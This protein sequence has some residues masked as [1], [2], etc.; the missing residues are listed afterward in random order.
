MFVTRYLDLFTTFYSVYNS[1]VK[2]LYITATAT[3]IWLIRFQQPINYNFEQDSFPHWKFAVAPC[4]L[5]ALVTHYS[6]SGWKCFDAM[7]LLW[8]F[9]IYLESIA[10][11]PQLL[12]LRKYRLVENL[13]GKFVFFLGIYR[14]LYCFNWIYR[15]HTERGYQHHWV[16]YG[17]GVLQTLLYVDF[18]YQYCKATRL[19]ASCRG[20][21]GEGTEAGEDDEDDETRLLFESDRDSSQREELVAVTEAS[22]AEPLLLEVDK[23]TPVQEDVRRRNGLV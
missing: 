19:C 15:A 7:E 5:V 23:E 6:G 1:V 20:R 22:V 2:I 13:T 17:C 8:T 3:I 12:V 16:V 14:F 9:S 10:I 21:K 4:A 18:F 11:L